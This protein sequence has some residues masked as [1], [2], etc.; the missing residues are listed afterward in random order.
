MIYLYNLLLIA[1]FIPAA[2]AMAV[3]YRKKLGS[4]FFYKTPERLGLWDFTQENKADKPLLWVHCA[5]LG[6]VKAVEPVLRKLRG[7]R[8]LLTTV[9]LSG[10]QHALESKLADYIYFAPIDYSFLVRNAIKN[11]KISALLLVETEL[12]PGLIYE[13]SRHGAKVILLNGRLSANSYPSYRMFSFFWKPVLSKI[14]FLLARSQE[15]AE[16][17]SNIGYPKDRITVTGNIK[18]DTG[19]DK[20]KCTKEELGFKASDMIWVCG[21]SG[22]LPRWIWR[23]RT[24]CRCAG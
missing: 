9:T 17:F 6:E 2:I 16:R 7:Y 11:I 12:W 18:Y 19:G 5:S 4:E 20:P 13:A 3:H 21:S 14:D 22:R 8:I 1:L 23:W 24:M 10:R 15:D